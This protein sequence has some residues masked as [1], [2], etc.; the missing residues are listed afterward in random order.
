MLSEM[1]VENKVI[2][3]IRIDSR[4]SFKNCNKVGHGGD[5]IGLQKIILATM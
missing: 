3:G 1:R 5:K 2:P 4:K